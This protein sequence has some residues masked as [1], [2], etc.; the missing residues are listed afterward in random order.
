MFKF[1]LLNKWPWEEG[2]KPDAKNE[3]ASIWVEEDI[4]KYLRTDIEDKLIKELADSYVAICLFTN[5]EEKGN[6]EWVIGD[7]E[8]IY[9]NATALETLYVL[10]DKYKLLYTFK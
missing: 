1:G 9:D 10:C 6:Y 7:R 3:K 5:G 4:T 2:I 8:G